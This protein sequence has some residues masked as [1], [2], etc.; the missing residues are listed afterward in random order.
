[1]TLFPYTTLFRSLAVVPSLEILPF[2]VRVLRLRHRRDA[3]V[4][5]LVRVE[6]LQEIGEPDSFP[7][8][9]AHLLAGEVQKL[10]GGHVVGKVESFVVAEEDR[11]PY[12]RVEH[13][14][15]LPDEIVMPR[16]RIV[17]KVLPSLRLI[18]AP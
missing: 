15:V 10:R 11:R 5:D 1:S 12:D 17:P 2:E 3:I 18:S 16:L 4:P 8:P 6:P 13:D 14:V 9:G 7:S